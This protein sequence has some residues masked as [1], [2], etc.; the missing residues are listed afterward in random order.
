MGGLELVHVSSLS[1]PLGDS[2]KEPDS[3]APGAKELARVRSILLQAGI[4]DAEAEGLGVGT[5]IFSEARRVIDR[6]EQRQL[7]FEGSAVL[8][9]ER[10]EG[11]KEF[12][13]SQRREIEAAREELFKAR[14]E[15]EGV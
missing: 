6:L 13:E 11:S 9:H 1:G 2:P 5:Y 14:S 10:Y 7:Q 15:L 12:I 8:V 3:L 4:G